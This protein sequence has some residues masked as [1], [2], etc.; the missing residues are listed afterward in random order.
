MADHLRILEKES[1]LELIPVECPFLA[2]IQKI[3]PIIDTC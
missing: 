3:I 2:Q 1:D